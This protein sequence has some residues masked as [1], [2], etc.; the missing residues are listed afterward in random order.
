[1]IPAAKLPDA[2]NLLDKMGAYDYRYYE[3]ND[4]H[5]GVLGDGVD[6]F[7]EDILAED[8]DEVGYG[9]QAEETEEVIIIDNEPLF[10]DELAVQ[11]KKQRRRKRGDHGVKI[12]SQRTKGF[13]HD[14][15][16]LLCKSWIEM[17]Q[18]AS[19]PYQGT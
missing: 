9:E 19:F 3:G 17:G 13:S 8:A 10:V 15:D 2:R 16:V 4:G 6:G 18:D 14:E 7:L 5:G 11:A 1:M 12:V